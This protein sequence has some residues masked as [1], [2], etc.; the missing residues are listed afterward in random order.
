MYID[1]DQ[2]VAPPASQ[3]S[4]KTGGSQN[5][6]LSEEASLINGSKNLY[7]VYVS[8]FRSLGDEALVVRML[9]LIV[10]ECKLLPYLSAQTRAGGKQQKPLPDRPERLCLGSAVCL[11]PRE[12]ERKP[13]VT[14]VSSSWGTRVLAHTPAPLPPPTTHKATEPGCFSGWLFSEGAAGASCSLQR[15][16]APCAESSHRWTGQPPS[17]S[18]VSLTWLCPCSRLQDRRVQRR[19]L[20]RPQRRQEF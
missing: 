20:R 2:G 17:L 3:P 11:M 6:D 4:C 13:P 15:I 12:G 16:P 7:C 1:K 18:S 19:H 9:L 14:A 8:C 5:F 10:A